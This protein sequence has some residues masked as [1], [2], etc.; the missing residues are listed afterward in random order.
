[1]RTETRRKLS[2]ERARRGL[3]AAI[4]AMT[5]AD[6][7]RVYAHPRAQISGENLIVMCYRNMAYH[8]GQINLIQ[9][10][11][12]DAEFHLPPKWR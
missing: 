9:M 8:V 7:S 10:L 1:M 3:A 4:R 2:C 12:G 6:L 11:Y 5:E